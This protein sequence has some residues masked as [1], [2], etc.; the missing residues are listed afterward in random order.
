MRTLFGVYHVFQWAFLR[1]LGVA[2]NIFIVRAV[3][4][5]SVADTLSQRET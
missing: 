4:P 5:Y 3:F 1:V 2:D